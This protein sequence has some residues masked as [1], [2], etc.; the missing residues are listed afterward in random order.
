MAVTTSAD[1]VHITPARSVE[2]NRDLPPAVE[3]RHSTTATG[4]EN[5]Q[6]DTRPSLSGEW[7]STEQLARA[8]VGLAD[9]RLALAEQPPQLLAERIVE[10]LDGELGKIARVLATRIS[11]DQAPS[12]GLSTSLARV[13][14]VL[15][16]LEGIDGQ[17][18]SLR[19]APPDLSI[20][21][22]WTSTH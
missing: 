7:E 6:G 17:G 21:H 10:A 20:L 18:G 2:F 13:E 5:I 22:E 8:I 11:N 19:V 3:P 9:F 4:G 12:D 1:A 14:W 15:S 16:A